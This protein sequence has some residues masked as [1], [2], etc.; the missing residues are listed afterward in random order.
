MFEAGVRAVVGL[1]VGV[2]LG[3][4]YFGGLW[5]T[6]RKLQ[7]AKNPAF[8][9]VMSFNARL[10]LTMLGFFFVWQAGGRPDWLRL[11]SAV[12][13]F[14]VARTLLV[15]KLGQRGLSFGDERRSRSHRAE[16]GKGGDGAAQS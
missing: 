3:Y 14:L 9:A 6:I 16:D 10:V 11:L 12:A 2:V 4:V 7:T 15:H 13:G 8:L 5:L 1:V